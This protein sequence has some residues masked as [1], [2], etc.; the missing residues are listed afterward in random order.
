[1]DALRAG[2]D[3]ALLDIGSGHG[4]S[5][6]LFIADRTSAGVTATD[7]CDHA[8]SLR[9]QARALGHEAR[10]VNGSIRFLQVDATRLPFA[11]A[12]FS[13]VSAISTIEHIPGDGDTRD[14][15]DGAML[16]R[17]GGW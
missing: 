9:A 6:P 12:S 3:H 11:D 13:R 2:P 4:G 17:V 10:L 14:P 7:I 16:R 5:F 15:R 8:E 1:V